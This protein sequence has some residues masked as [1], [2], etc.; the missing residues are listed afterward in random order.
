KVPQSGGV[1][2]PLAAFTKAQVVDYYVR[3]APFIVPHLKDRPVTL[4][5][6]P[7]EAGGE[8]F[9]EKDAPAYTPEWV[10]RFPVMRR[11]GESQIN[12]IIVDDLHTLAWA[13]SVGTVEFHTFLHRVPEI[14]RPTWVVFD[15]DL[16]EPA[17]VLDCGRVALMLRDL[18]H[19]LELHSFVKV[20][21]SKGL[22]VYV[23]LNT[24]VTYK[25]TQPF[26]RAVAM[27]LGMEHPDM[28][29]SEMERVQR[30][31][32]VFID[33]SQNADHKTTVC[34][35]SLRAKRRQPY[36][37][38]PV[39][40]EEL[41]RALDSRQ[42][43]A[44]YFSPEEALKRLQRAGDLFAPVLTMRQELPE[45]FAAEPA[46]AEVQTPMSSQGSPRRLLHMPAA[47]SQGGRRQFTLWRKTSRGPMRLELNLHD[48]TL[49]FELPEG[50][51]KRQ[52][53]VLPAST[54][55]KPRSGGDESNTAL[56]EDAGVFELIEGDPKKEYLDLYFT[57]RKLRGEL[58]ARANAAEGANRW[59][60]LRPNTD[61]SGLTFTM[62]GDGSA[63]R[64]EPVP[65]RT[66]RK[67]ARVHRDSSVES[68]RSKPTRGA[69]A[70]ELSFALNEFPAANPVFVPPMEC[71]LV[72]SVPDQPH[73][74][75]E[76]KLDGYRA[77]AVKAGE[78]ADL[79]SR[80]G[81]S[82]KERFRHIV[83][84]LGT[85]GAD[86]FV[87]DGEVV[88]LDEQGR[89][90][91][92]EL[93]NSRST[94]RPIVYYVFDILNYSGNDLRYV[95]LQ[96]RKRMLEAVAKSFTGPVRLAAAVDVNAQTLLTQVKRLELEGIVAKDPK[97]IYESG[98]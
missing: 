41:K 25:E 85:I 36:V 19:R 84:A 40:W 44:L 89:P 78:K 2:F 55:L 70:L 90:S 62:P 34:V 60:V 79:F 95:P 91:F 54:C 30:K 66:S 22:Q 94:R 69:A 37:S 98:K 64:A 65:K 45:T 52:G 16:G 74:L 46:G 39:T 83:S 18:L 6:S 71:K 17:N 35:Y 77:I 12:Y 42:A 23:P 32:R 4:K 76:L 15:L 20:S 14:G 97:S 9:W 68:K 53:Q 58:I 26:A 7:D 47:S 13:A 50:L 75:F 49:C 87:L 93:Q 61:Q 24:E 92:Q 82:F 3:V 51:P 56:A 29:V 21:G 67:S 1:V 63:G 38:A 48:K 88:A 31:G 11:S 8:F 10:R 72:Q 81:R 43:A 73:W 57:G 5:R 59:I 27:M 80:Y 86:D 96:Q 28:I 33:W